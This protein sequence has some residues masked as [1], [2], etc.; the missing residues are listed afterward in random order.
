MK[1]VALSGWLAAFVCSV[2]A[3]CVAQA[4]TVAEAPTSQ[5]AD[6]RPLN[7]PIKPTLTCGEFTALLKSGDKRTGGLA[8]LWL[9]GFYS[10]APGSPNC[11]PAGHGP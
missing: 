7:Q 9:D 2:A 8:I 11:P 1:G 10:A 3:G 6:P 4:P 5:P